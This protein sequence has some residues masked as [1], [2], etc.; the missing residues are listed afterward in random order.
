MAA[1]LNYHP[2]LY[3]GESI[4][5]KKLDKIKK[6]L[7]NKP[8]LS[9]V[10]LIALSRNPSDQLEIYS[11]RQ[12]AQKYYAKYP[13]YVVGIAGNYDE[14]MKMVERMVQECV[15]KRGDCALKEYLLCRK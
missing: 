15:E 6:K 7:E 5:E 14:A 13:P 8:L 2:D 3:L 11:A 4:R 9:G 10:F 1:K 12:L